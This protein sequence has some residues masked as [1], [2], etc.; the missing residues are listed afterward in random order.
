M[1]ILRACMADQSSEVTSAGVKIPLP[2]MNTVFSE[3]R[4]EES[5]LKVM[6]GPS[7]SITTESSALTSQVSDIDKAK[8]SFFASKKS[9]NSEYLKIYCKFCQRVGHVVEDCY[10]KPGSKVKPP[11]WSH[12]QNN[13]SRQSHSTEKSNMSESWRSDADSWRPSPKAAV[14]EVADASQ[15]NTSEPVSQLVA[16]LKVLE[17]QR[18]T[19]NAEQIRATMASTGNG[20]GKSD[21]WVVDS[22]ATHHMT[23]NKCLLNSFTLFDNTRKVRVANG[24]YADIL[25]YGDICL[26]KTM[27]LKHVLYVPSLDCNLISVR[28][29]MLDNDCLTI[30]SPSKCYFLPSSFSCF[31]E[32]AM[33]EKVL[34]EKIGYASLQDGLFLLHNLKSGCREVFEGNSRVYS[35][36]DKTTVPRINSMQSRIDL[37][38]LWHKRLGHPNFLY[39][40][41]IRPELFNNIQLDWLKCET[42]MYAKQTRVSYPPKCYRESRPFN[43]IHSDIWGPS[44]VLNVNGCRWFVVFV[45]DHTRVTWVYL[46]KHKYELCSV[47][48]VFVNLIQNQFNEVVK[49]FRTDNGSEY[50]DKDVRLFLEEKGIHHHT[51]NV[52]TP[53]QN[54]VA[55]RKHRHLL[56]VARSLMFSMNV[57]KHMWGEAV[58][59]ATYLINRTPSR[60]LGFISP[61]QKLLGLYPHCLLMSE[62]PFRTFECTV[63]VFLQV[64][65]RGK[66]D[67]RS[68]KCMFI[69]Y[70][71][72]QKGYK[73]FCPH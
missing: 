18:S 20:D 32:K 11:P 23:F 14:A 27:S 64:H 22:G 17:N 1:Y 38:L 37:V 44:R 4:Q 19:S 62:I 33:K 73:C 68:I 46:M 67:K 30:F 39:L 9:G 15:N 57:P 16:M 65:N 66:L 55:E 7:S 34:K 56:G 42:C 51:S 10:R 52:Y 2:P 60:V 53:Q 43:L 6:M 59:T 70:A 35:C 3:V 29:L 13:N 63:Y 49:N 54:G 26:S 24:Y 50:M 21:T 58:L 72:T 41:K 8:N 28:R 48:K 45:D 5:R 36:M 69:G 47:L 25:G 40:R 12:K 31:Q 61:R 71:G